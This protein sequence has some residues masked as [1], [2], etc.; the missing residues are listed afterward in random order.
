MNRA[1]DAVKVR[2]VRGTF[3]LVS[4]T[5]DVGWQVTDRDGRFHWFRH[6][7]IKKGRRR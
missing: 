5:N 2:G 6:S 4:E 3:T 1:G 7:R